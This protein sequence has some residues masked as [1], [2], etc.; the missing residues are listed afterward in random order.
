M[1]H[2]IQALKKEQ[3]NGHIASVHE[4]KKP[5]KCNICDASFTQKGEIIGHFATVHE[6]KKALKG[7]ICM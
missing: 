5:F 7:N 2:V 4:G 6:G 3:I 1:Q